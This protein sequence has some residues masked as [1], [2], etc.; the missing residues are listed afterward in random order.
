[1]RRFG[2]LKRLVARGPLLEIR[3]RLDRRSLD[4]LGRAAGLA[5]SSSGTDTLSRIEAAIGRRRVRHL[6]IIVPGDAAAVGRVFARRYP[7]AQV[8][9]LVHARRGNLG[10]PRRRVTIHRTPTV[11]DM[12]EVLSALPR[13]QV[14][15]EATLEK[16]VKTAVL[17]HLLFHV[18]EDGV[19]VVD[20]L[21]SLRDPERQAV[22]GMDVWQGLSRILRVKVDPGLVE[23]ERLPADEHARAAAIGRAAHDGHLVTVDKAGRHLLQLHDPDAETVL[24]GRFGATWGRVLGTREPV[25]EPIRGRASA[26]RLLETFRTEMP[27]PRMYLRE[28]RDVVCAP[29][30]VAVQ[31]DVVLPISFHHGLRDRLQTRSPLLSPADTHF[32]VPDPSLGAAERMPGAYYHLDSEFPGHFGHFMTE[33]IAKL[34]GWSAARAA[35]PGIK[36][37]VST[38]EP[39]G[40]P[41]TVQR[42]LIA[43]WGIPESD[44]VCI[45]R[46]VRVDVLVG[47]TQMFYNGIYVHP[48]MLAVWARL[49]EALRSP[50]GERPAHPRRLFVTRAPTALRPCGNG[51]EVEALFAD[52]GF[53]I[54]RP[55]QLTIREQ[56]DRFAA[57][58]VI[59]GYGGSG[60]FNAIYTERPVR[61]IVIS[62]DRYLARNEWAIAAAKGDEYHHFFGESELRPG[63]G[64]EGWRVFQSPFTFD[65][66]RDGDALRALLR[67]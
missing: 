47:A 15:V 19:Y 55:E 42:T 23:H 39:G 24:A 13:P 1:V 5:T 59:A 22:R 46:P 63:E 54:V 45:D 10:R 52:H 58:E 44:V 56:V 11:H 60:M 21:D 32:A 8:H 53:D 3:D 18:E 61:W 4:E 20:R 28:Y 64:V 14:L 51:A 35:H 67:D 37:L 2:R 66:A 7:G 65:L 27:V 29:R 36:L 12:H 33:D 40:R 62:S 43:A 50:E 30:Q 48:E 25:D 34:W 49:R 26:N 17:R 41:T 38:L 16:T 6:A 57:A 31:G 9:V